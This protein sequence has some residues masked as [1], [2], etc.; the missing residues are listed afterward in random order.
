MFIANTIS[1]I[2]SQLQKE[3]AL[4]KK[5]AFVPTMGALHEGHLALVRKAQALADIVVVSIFVNKAQFNDQ[6]DYKN[7]PRQNE[8]DLQKLKNCSV[9]YIFLPTDKEMFGTDFS[10]QIIP[11][12]L[13]DCL[14]GSSRLGHFEGVTLIVTKLFNIIRPEIAIFGEKDF[15]QLAVIKKLDQD[16]NLGVEIFSHETLREESGLAMSSR[17]QKLSESSVIKA[18]QLFT[19]LNEIRSEVTK[20]PEKITEIL[21]EKSQKL[22]AKGFEKI[23]YLEIRNEKNLE[24]VANFHQPQPCR[25]FVAAYLEGVRLIDNLKL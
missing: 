2:K 7:Y 16:L 15:Q 18:S 4:Q 23:D 17:N 24:L 3:R 20:S 12:K 6:N 11:T 19:V 22:L 25:I 21:R 8:Q 1:E 10:H 5:I 9:D 13:T 14:C